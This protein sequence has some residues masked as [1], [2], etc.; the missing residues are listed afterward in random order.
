MESSTCPRY[1]IFLSI[2]RDG[3]VFDVHVKQ[4]QFDFQSGCSVLDIHRKLCFSIG[5][6]V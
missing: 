4:T 6:H 5:L 1:A 2:I 3:T